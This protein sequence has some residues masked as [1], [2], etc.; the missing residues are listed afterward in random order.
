MLAILKAGGAYV[1][2][3]PA[4]PEERI[5]FILADSGIRLILTRQHLLNGL[6][7]ASP[8]TD[9]NGATEGLR[10]EWLDLHEETAAGTDASDLETA[11]RPEHPNT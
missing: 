5:R 10:P 8:L 4:Y 7:G 6:L 9:D 11:V 1:P 2:I 3:D